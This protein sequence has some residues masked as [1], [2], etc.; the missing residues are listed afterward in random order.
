MFAEL[1]ATALHSCLPCFA[2]ISEA[3]QYTPAFLDSSTL[4]K[5]FFLQ[6]QPW[7]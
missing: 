3:L 6:I 5:N 7:G 4:K 1:I 2:T